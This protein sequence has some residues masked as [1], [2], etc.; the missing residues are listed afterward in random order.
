MTD[1]VEWFDGLAAPKCLELHGDAVRCY[2]GYDR[3]IQIDGISRV[4]GEDIEIVAP[5]VAEALKD[6]K[7]QYEFPT[8]DVVRPVG[9]NDAL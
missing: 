9:S 6:P 8:V 5:S 4:V 3:R 7:V 1:Y 2:F